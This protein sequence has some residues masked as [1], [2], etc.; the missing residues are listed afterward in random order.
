MEALELRHADLVERFR[1]FMNRDAMRRAR[2]GIGPDLIS[3]AAE[4]LN[5]RQDAPGSRAGGGAATPP[6]TQEQK[7]ALYRKITH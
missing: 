6:S 4:V 3:E 2:G 5:S 7:L 1:Y